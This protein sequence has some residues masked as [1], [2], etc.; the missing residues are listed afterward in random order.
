MTLHNI[1]FKK[2]LGGLSGMGLMFFSVST[3]S[4]LYTLV[5]LHIFIL[6]YNK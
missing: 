4:Y 1:F 3:L 2:H 5:F 6:N